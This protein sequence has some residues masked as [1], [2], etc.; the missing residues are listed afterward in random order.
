MNLFIGLMSGT[1]MDGIDAAL[2][3]LSTQALI[4]GL[5]I[6][7]S[8]L[9]RDAIQDVLE[10]RH[11][12]A[13]YSQLNTLLGREFA[14]AVHQLLKQTAIPHSRIK[15][16]GS[17]G[18][19]LC[20][21]TQANIPYTVQLGCGHT[22]AELTGITVVADFRTRDLVLGGQ[23]AP[24]AP[25]YHQALFSHLPLPLAVV[26]VGGLAN[27]TWLNNHEVSGFDTGPGNC[28]MDAWIRRHQHQPFDRQGVWAASG[29]VIDELLN[30][31]LADPYFAQPA[32]K[33]LGK[34]YFNDAWLQTRLKPHYLPQ[35]VQATLLAFTAMTVAASIRAQAITPNQVLICGGGAHN[36]QLLRVLQQ[37]LP[38]I[39][40]QSTANIGINPDFIEAQLFAWLAE[41]ALSGTPL[42]LSQVTGAKGR[43][44]LGA[45]YAA[46]I[47]KRISVEV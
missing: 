3:D 13:S 37:Q 1:S 36:D 21:N 2:V 16:I 35:D 45:I 24:F 6:P 19:T 5:T 33:S 42:D 43:A 27:L 17:H 47:D 41:K 39:T 28:L 18:Q 34:E 4:E 31:L 30:G 40:I 44:V 26:N 10:G 9:A 22:I 8:S 14:K 46:G 29:T 11:T 32:P 20:H 15:A 12:L 25:I 23:G 7:Y 38:E